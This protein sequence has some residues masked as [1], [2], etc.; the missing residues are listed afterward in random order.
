MMSVRTENQVV[1][2]AVF[3]E[4]LH[5]V[6]YNVVCADRSRS[7][8]IS[9]AANRR[10][11]SPK[12]LGNLDRERAHT[13]RRAINQNHLAALNLALVTDSLKRGDCRDGYDRCV[14]ERHI[15]RLQRQLI[16]HCTR[17]LGEPSASKTCDAEHLVTGPKPPCIPARCFDSACDVT[18]KDL[19]LWCAR[20]ANQW[21]TSHTI[22]VNGINRCGANVNQ[23]LIVLGYGFFHIGEL[24]YIRWP[25][26]RAYNRLHEATSQSS[27][28]ESYCGCSTR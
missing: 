13:T 24:Q 7:L 9:R 28:V 22:Q 23:D 19:L 25:V 1:S 16:F 18:T 3:C 20:P 21:R 8:Q 26:L 12:R 2:R 6:V 4:V 27:A 11:L 15:D 17:K 5:R 14:L 10:D